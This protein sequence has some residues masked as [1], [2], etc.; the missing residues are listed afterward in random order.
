MATAKTFEKRDLYA[1]VTDKIVAM[2]EQGVRP[3]SKSWKATDNGPKT[4]RFS[5]FVMPIR[6]TGEYYRGVNVVLLWMAAEANGFKQPM[7]LTFK[8]AADMGG[9]VKKGEKGTTIVHYHFIKREVEDATGAKSEQKI[10]SIRSFTVFNVEQCEGLPTK[11]F[12]DLPK[13]EEAP[14]PVPAAPVLK[15]LSMPHVD[16]FLAKTGAV[17][18]HGGSRAF[19]SIAGDYCQ[20]PEM[21]AFESSEAY[22]GTKIH[23]IVHWTG[24]TKRCAREFG[25]RFGDNA[26]AF[27]ELVAELGAAFECAM[28][29]ISAEPREDHASYLTNWLNVL[30]NDKRAIFT[31]ASYATK[32]CDFLSASSAEGDDEE[33]VTEEG[34]QAQTSMAA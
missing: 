27:E 10:P 24:N 26:Y 25:K 7:W 32:A 19:Y 9:H 29:G 4:R 6:V 22:Y 34:E 20:M 1:E 33:A 3:W 12:R 17:F 13:E 21:E 23:E 16:E 2:M 8:A 31:A 11:C 14:A 18:K 15:N 5:N 30:K 28:L